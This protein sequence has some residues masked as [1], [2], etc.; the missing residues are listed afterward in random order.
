MDL[1]ENEIQLIG[2]LIN[3]II[4]AVAIGTLIYQIKFNTKT[5]DYNLHPIFQVIDFCPTITPFWTPKLC[6]SADPN[7]KHY[8]TDDHWFD[9]KNLSNGPAF[10]FQCYLIHT[11][12]IN[13]DLRISDFKKRV[14]KREAFVNRGNLQYKIPTDAIPFRFYNKASTDQ[15]NII[16]EYKTANLSSKFRQII[17]LTYRPKLKQSQITDWKNAVEIMMPE[18]ISLKKIQWWESDQTTLMNELLKIKE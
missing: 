11:K 9:I 14:I 6:D 4:A 15:L 17:A 8:C 13:R 1:T 3:S 16:L 2:I 5:L 10:E 7:S 12:E 18:V